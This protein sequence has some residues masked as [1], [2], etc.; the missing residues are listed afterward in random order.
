MYCYMLSGSMGVWGN[1][2]VAEI[3]KS[4]CSSQ[5]YTCCLMIGYLVSYPSSH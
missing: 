2:T 5:V 4:F 3:Q 1:L